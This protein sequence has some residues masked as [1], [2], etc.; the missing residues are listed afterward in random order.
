MTQE[1]EIYE[2]KKEIEKLNE[3]IQDLQFQNTVLE[4]KVHGSRYD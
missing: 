3:K 2:L 1:E 4:L